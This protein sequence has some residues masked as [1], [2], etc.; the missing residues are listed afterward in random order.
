MYPAY[1]ELPHEPFL[2]PSTTPLLEGDDRVIPVIF[3]QMVPIDGAHW[4]TGIHLA[5]VGT[6]VISSASPLVGTTPA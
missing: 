5:E 3:T 6:H 1:T 2:W 4:C